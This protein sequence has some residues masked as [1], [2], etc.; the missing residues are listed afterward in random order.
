MNEPLNIEITEEEILADLLYPAS[1]SAGGEEA[2]EERHDLR[3]GERH[4]R[5][6]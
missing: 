6:L 3:F 1:A 2:L 5:T 4:R